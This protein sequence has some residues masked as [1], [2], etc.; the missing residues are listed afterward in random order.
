MS[1]LQ[2]TK[3][4]DMNSAKLFHLTT[5]PHELKVEIDYTDGK[6]TAFLSIT[7]HEVMISN[8]SYSGGGDKPTEDITINFTSATQDKH[9][10]GSDISGTAAPGGWLTEKSKVN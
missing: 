2:I 7:L 10:V 8:I 4:M 9:G 3:Y 5:V 1:E 6:G